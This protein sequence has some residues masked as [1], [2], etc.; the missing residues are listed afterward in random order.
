[1]VKCAFK[2]NERKCSILTQ[3]KCMR[4]NFYKTEEDVKANRAKAAERLEVLPLAIRL[5][6]AEKYTEREAEG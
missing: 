5:K 1:M 4:C 2:I 3:K 6:I